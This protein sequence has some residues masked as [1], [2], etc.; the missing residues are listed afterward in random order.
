MTTDPSQINEQ[1]LTTLALLQTGARVTFPD[2]MY[3]EGI[4]A[5]AY[6]EVG[7]EWGSEGLWTLNEKGLE[8]ALLDLQK[9][10]TSMG[11]QAS[12]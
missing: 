8:N 6:L 4:P 3:L 1:P 2:G 5:T 11:E 10:R 12:E 7:T 9:I